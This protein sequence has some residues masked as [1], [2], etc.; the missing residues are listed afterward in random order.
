M[1]LSLQASGAWGM[2]W[3]RHSVK[4]ERWMDLSDARFW[5]SGGREREIR[6]VLGVLR[7]RKRDIGVLR[8]VFTCLVSIRED[9]LNIVITSLGAQGFSSTFLVIHYLVIHYFVIHD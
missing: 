5:G 1:R 9:L 2:G 3:S 6:A 7:E 8:E 4:M